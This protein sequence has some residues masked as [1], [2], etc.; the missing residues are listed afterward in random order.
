MLPKISLFE[1]LSENELEALNNIASKSEI[2]RGEII[3]HEGD[4]N[5][6]LFIV[7]AGEIEIGVI[8]LTGTEK[9][10][11]RI[12]EKEF[13]GEMSLY[14][15]TSA[16][17]TTARVVRSGNLIR[18]PSDKL[19]PLIDAP[20]PM[21]RNIS[22]KIML[23][24]SRRLRE[25]T[26]R[27]AAVLKCEENIK[28][29]VISVVSSGSGCGK[30]TF[31]TTMAHI[32]AREQKRKV[33]FLDLDLHYGDGSFLL[34]VYSQ[35]S[36][37]N[38]ARIIHNPD[39]TA[40]Q[41]QG[42][43]SL[44]H[45]NLHILSAPNNIIEA[46]QL[47]VENL[48]S[49]IGCC[50]KLFDYV[51][52][53][54][55]EGINPVVLAAIEASEH[56]FFMLDS[57]DILN[58]KNSVRFFQVLNTLRFPE[59]KVTVL[60]NK[61]RED[62]RP[63]HL[64]KTRLRIAGCLPEFQD[65]SRKDGKTVFQMSPQ[66]RF[67]SAVRTV[68]TTIIKDENNAR[69][70]INGNHGNGLPGSKDNGKS[71]LAG[72]GDHKMLFP[73]ITGENLSI[74]INE[75]K[76]LLDEGMLPEAEAEARELLKL[77]HDS[78]Q[79]YQVFGEILI[80]REIPEE[81]I[82]VMRKAIELDANNLLATGM[83]GHLLADRDQLNRTIQQMNERCQK[84]ARFADCWNDLG[85]LHGLAGNFDDAQ[86]AFRK[87]LEINPAF[88][89]ARI[90][91]AIALGESGQPGPALKELEQLDHKGLRGHYFAGCFHQL[92]G[93]FAE[94]YAEFQMATVIRPEYHDLSK[95]LEHL[96]VY[97][98]KIEALV[99]MHRN[100]LTRH[101]AFPDLHY[102]LAELYFQ[103]AKE[104]EA[105]AELQEALRL[106]PNYKEA[107]QRLSQITEKAKVAGAG[108]KH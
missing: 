2:H 104:D 20:T 53:D 50:Q 80:C 47:H 21:S 13:F 100:Y 86:K 17:S 14:D 78:S 35:N 7:E 59:N 95:R 92:Q 5:W 36:I 27:A 15:R 1:D 88:R 28:G 39:V 41:I 94:A 38:L 25:V 72:K 34:G 76:L 101:P 99:Q 108:K 54:T 79:L 66:N 42:H 55:N 63:E 103:M 23:A 81:A 89:D 22:S 48:A 44:I 45:E 62:F 6:D 90:N 40:E 84:S 71:M 26:Q 56:V 64:P 70:G 85:R 106:N 74:L 67:C 43:F 98:S 19:W 8:D 107:R 10:I 29:K 83:L 4:K 96:G 33:L 49:I 3:F 32:I 93:A 58:V 105:V 37:V 9:V 91:L 18:L 60:A 97:F 73:S 16:R 51:V 46:E 24:L 75:L 102:K 87:A 12:R 65:L 77:C 11:A 57:Q 30:T 82:I 31:A 61:A 69:N 52:V 68:V